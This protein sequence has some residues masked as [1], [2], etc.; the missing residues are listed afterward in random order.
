MRKAQ[1]DAWEHEKKQELKYGLA[2]NKTVAEAFERYRDEVSPTKR[3][4]KWEYIRLNAFLKN[5]TWAQEP[6]ANI[7]VPM[8]AQWRDDRL[9]KVQAPSVRREM[10]LLTS[11]FEIARR[12]WQWIKTNPCRD[13]KRPPSNPHRTRRV[14]Q[15]EIDRICFALGYSQ[16]EPVETKSA[17][18]AVA[19]LFALET[20]MRLGEILGLSRENVDLRRRVALLPKTKNGH[21]RQVPLTQEACRLLQQLP[22]QDE[23]WFDLNVARCDALFRKYVRRSGVEN[24][25]FHDARKEATARLAKKLDVMDLAKVTGHR[26]LKMLL[27]CYYHPSP[28]EIAEKLSSADRTTRQPSQTGISDRP[29]KDLGT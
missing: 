28:E 8:V 27:E 23:R 13:V 18:A 22:E 14:S 2:P 5:I 11:V 21:A 29:R 7:T 24:L 26:D 3:G 1:A 19:F 17:Q 25:H 10:G 16:D 12:E 9:K 15:D 20:A 6:I 4:A